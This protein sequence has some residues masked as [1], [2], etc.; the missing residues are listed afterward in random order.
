MQTDTTDTSDHEDA[1]TAARE[2]ERLERQV[3]EME[4]TL[5]AE[6]RNA[7]ISR[8]ISDHNLEP[9]DAILLTGQDEA[10]LTAQAERLAAR[11]SDVRTLGNVAPREGA[12]KV[13]GTEDRDIREFAALLFGR[14][15]EL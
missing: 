3:A 9:E 2:T 12:T 10:T 11:S 13:T 7:L 5:A 6:K 8:I 14:A 4:E 15:D 1:T